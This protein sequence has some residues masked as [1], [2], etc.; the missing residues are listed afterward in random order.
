MALVVVFAGR[1]SAVVYPIH[2]YTP[3]DGLLTYHSETSLHWLD[4]TETQNLACTEIEADV[5]GWASAGFRHATGAEVC[6]LVEETGL[7]PSPC[8][9]D[10]PGVTAP[11]DWVGDLQALIGVTTSD[12]TQDS[13]L[14][15]Y[16]DGN[17]DPVRSGVGWIVYTSDTDKSIVQVEDDNLPC[18]RSPSVG[19]FLVHPGLVDVTG[20]WQFNS[21]CGVGAGGE[22]AGTLG[23]LLDEH[24]VTGDAISLIWGAHCGSILVNG[25]IREI[26]SCSQL[27]ITVESQV[28]AS[29]QLEIPRSSAGSWFIYD[30]TFARPFPY[31]DLNPPCADPPV[32]RFRME[33]HITGDITDDGGG[34]ATRVD[35]AMAF[36]H[37]LAFNTLDQLCF[38]GPLAPFACTYTALRNG[39]SGS[40]QTVEPLEGATVTFTGVGTQG[41][42]SVTR[43]TESDGQMPANFKLADGLYY[44]VSTTAGSLTP[45]I[46]VCLPYPDENPDDGYVD[47]VSPPLHEDDL[48]I[49]HEEGSS[50]VPLTVVS[51]DPVGNTL[52]AE[53]ASLSQFVVAG[54]AAIGVPSLSIRGFVALSTLMLLGAVYAFRR[55][56]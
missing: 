3:G 41:V 16:D 7:V 2:L 1:G 55:W 52:C 53:T 27:P 51:R 12:A 50:F 11:G 15:Y 25:E 14:G 17:G 31:P 33:I 40:N 54:P 23:L 46:T 30:V 4:L 20:T 5:G 35:G 13:S 32:G 36:G 42:V 37:L 19:H 28:T 24:T 6:S 47:L 39:V 56:G 10:F 38:S 29:D 34:R 49:L 18:N 21:D 26:E 48:V 9:G 22:V 45:P 8:P 43:L 44:D